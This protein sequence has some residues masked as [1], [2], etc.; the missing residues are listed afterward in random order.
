[1]GLALTSNGVVGARTCPECKP[2]DVRS[3]GEGLCSKV[4]KRFQKSRHE[5]NHTD[6]KSMGERLSAEVSE[7]CRKSCLEYNSR[8]K[9]QGC[10]YQ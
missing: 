7:R 4:R 10:G 2:K 6:V 8:D 1:M 9:G 3:M 5:Y